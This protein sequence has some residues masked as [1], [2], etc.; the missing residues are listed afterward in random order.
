MTH[1]LRIPAVLLCA[2]ALA[3][4]ASAIAQRGAKPATAT[5]N[6]ADAT[7]R[8]V[9]AAQALLATLD[10]AGRAKVQFPFEGPQKTRWSNLPT[11]IFAREG[12]RMG[13]LDAAAARGGDHPAA[14]RPERRWL[15]EG[16]GDRAQRRS[17]AQRGSPGGAPRGGGAPGGGGATRRWCGPG[18]RR[19]RAG[20]GPAPPP[21]AGGGRGVAARSD[22]RR[23]RVLPR[24]PRHAVD[25][26]AVDAAV[27]RTSPR[28]QPDDGGQPGDH[29]AEPAGRAAGDL[30]VRGAGNPAARQGERQG[31]RAD[32]RARREAARPGDSSARVSPTSCSAPGQDGRVI[33]PEGLRASAMSPAQQDMLLG[34]RRASGRAS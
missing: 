2:V 31:V 15:P 3:A 25:D 6:P 28:D 22:L 21:A 27:R 4:S 8:I 13:D 19:W 34:D 9:A 12:L 18:H 29:G 30:H 7:A 26:R 33:Q 20:A 32:Q 17:P 16:D 14:G 11:G 23:G 24:V 1:T 5:G 10:E